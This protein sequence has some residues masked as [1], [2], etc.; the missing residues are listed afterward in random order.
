MDP[1]TQGVVGAVVPQ[2]S[3]RKKQ[4]LLLGLFGWLSGMAPDLD[5]LI[6]S[7]HDPLLYL[8]YHRQFTHSL[9]FIPIGG[10]I[11][12]SLFYL[13][14]ARRFDL[15][16]KMTYLACTLGYGTHGLLDAATSYGTMLFW[17]FSDVR[18]AGNIISIIDPLFTLPLLILVLLAGFRRKRRYA[19]L[20][21]LWM[22]LYLGFGAVQNYRAERAGQEL[23]DLRGHHNVEV[24]AKPS[25]GNLLVWKV[26]YRHE[27]TYY[28]DAVRTGITPTVVEGDRIVA[29]DLQRD[30]PWLDANSQQARDIERFRWFSKGYIAK[31]PNY[32][33]RIIDLRYSLIP[34]EINAL[35][36]IS[37]KPEAQSEDHAGFTHHRNA[38]PR[39][40]QLLWQMILN[41]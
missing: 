39:E 21:L 19:L 2:A 13:L 33:D 31:D 14:L 15:S 26:I 24:S 16:F 6:R 10:L 3:L 23:A 30:F 11:C 25:F 8:E 41:K 27:N 9:I 38:G 4:L 22:G 5:V 29:L 7:T 17:P 1:L 36:S 28:V 34:N 32:E 18:V 12:A 40:R 20:G 37:L 35:W